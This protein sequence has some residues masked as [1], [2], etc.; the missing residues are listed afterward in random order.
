MSAA[1]IALPTF[2]F[3]TQLI[4][5][6]RGD[7]LG[8]ELQP[9]PTKEDP[10]APAV[11]DG[12][13]LADAL[14]DSG[15]Q[16]EPG[17]LVFFTLDRAALLKPAA[18][19][20]LAPLGGIL[21]PPDI[22]VDPLLRRRVAWLQASGY[23]MV[24][25]RVHQ[26]DDPRW[27]LAPHIDMIRL[28]LPAIHPQDLDPLIIRAHR[29][30]LRLVAC[31]ITLASELTWL[32]RRGVEYYQGPLTGAPWPHPAGELPGCD[33]T[34]LKVVLKLLQ[35]RAPT[36]RLAEEVIADPAL[37]LRL[38]LLQPVLARELTPYCQSGPALLEAV[39]YASLHAWVRLLSQTATGSH[40]AAWVRMVQEQ[41]GRFRIALISAGMLARREELE[42]RT[43][44]LY[45][46]MCLARPLGSARLAGPGSVD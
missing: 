33:A 9:L 19:L 18:E 46:R 3:T 44:A 17:Q 35:R 24:L 20:L 12:R 22:L 34:V 42:R 45:R 21:L 30:N 23:R 5:T 4:V 29:L 28:D 8:H 6:G 26:L 15:W 31:G 25:D 16:P 2:R 37:M 27:V 43:F 11:L 41:M 14:L 1:R 39:P 32:R 40:G 10:Q 38:F 13:V 7:P 36:G